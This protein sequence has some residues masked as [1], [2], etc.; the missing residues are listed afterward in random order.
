MVTRGISRAMLEKE[1]GEKAE[2]KPMYHL[3]KMAA[4]KRQLYLGPF[5]KILLVYAMV[6]AFGS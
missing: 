6:S 3:K 4:H 5:S 2:G 1:K